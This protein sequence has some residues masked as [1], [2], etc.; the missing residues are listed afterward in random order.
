MNSRIAKINHHVD[1]EIVIHIK[2]V[3]NGTGLI[4]SFANTLQ[5]ENSTII[6]LL[7]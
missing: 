3:V 6:F 5:C 1:T 7:N 4:V 2:K